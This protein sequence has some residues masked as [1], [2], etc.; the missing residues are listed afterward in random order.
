MSN[1]PRPGAEAL[2]FSAWKA[3][4][5]VEQACSVGSSLAHHKNPNPPTYHFISLPK[6]SVTAEC[7][8]NSKW[9]TMM[10]D[11]TSQRRVHISMRNPASEGSDKDQFIYK[12]VRKTLMKATS[13][14]PTSKSG[15]K[16]KKK[17]GLSAW[18]IALPWFWAKS[19]VSRADRCNVVRKRRSMSHCCRLRTF[20][21]VCAFA[22]SQS[23]IFTPPW[24]DWEPW[25]MPLG[26]AG[27]NSNRFTKLQQKIQKYILCFTLLFSQMNYGITLM[28]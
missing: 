2:T 19:S 16:K 6:M 15:L 22:S 27:P 1:P 3:A 13:E 12:E 9:T 8:F 23:R 18:K 10:W 7:G 28:E 21:K 24:G 4:H 26:G 14:V 17:D 11:T 25:E 5:S 20:G